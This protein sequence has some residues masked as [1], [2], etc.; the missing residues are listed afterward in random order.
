M[1]KTVSTCTIARFAACTTS[2]ITPKPIPPDENHF[3]M[4]RTGELGVQS[5]PFFDVKK[6]IRDEAISSL[7]SMLG[8][9]ADR[10][11]RMPRR[12]G[13]RREHDQDR[14]GDISHR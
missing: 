13:W 2:R 12:I 11:G 1:A 3:M 10:L 14:R 6:E 9:N 8:R 5:V 4:S 7:A